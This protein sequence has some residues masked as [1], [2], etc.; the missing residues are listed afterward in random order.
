[1][2][3]TIVILSVTI[4]ISANTRFRPDLSHS[5]TRESAYGVLVIAPYSSPL[6]DVAVSHQEGGLGDH[7][8]QPE[9]ERATIHASIILRSFAAHGAG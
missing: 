8:E 7:G 1:M 4:V 3:I 6:F 2:A 5:Y 9:P